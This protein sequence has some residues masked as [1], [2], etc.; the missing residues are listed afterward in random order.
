MI[1]RVV[2]RAAL[3]VVLAASLFLVPNADVNPTDTALVGCRAPRASTS[4]PD[5]VWIL[6]SAPT[7]G[8][9]RTH[10]QPGR[11]DPAG[12]DQHPDRGRDLDRRTPRLLRRIPGHGSEKINAAMYFGG[13]ELMAERSEPGRHRPDYVW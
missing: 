7:P 5:V 4:S 1:G 8:R 3:G 6:A 13:P 11:R 2:R 9:A 12:R 10:P